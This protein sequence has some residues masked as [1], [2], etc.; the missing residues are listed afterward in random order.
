MLIRMNDNMKALGKKIEQALEGRSQSWLARQSGVG[1]S[2]VS[3]LIR[4][5]IR[6]SPDPETIKAIANALG[7]DSSHFMTLAG[8]PLPTPSSQLDP[9]ALHIAERI[10]SLPNQQRKEAVK[11]MGSVLDAISII[12]KGSSSF[13]TQSRPVSH[14]T[15]LNGYDP[16]I[17]ILEPIYEDDPVEE[18]ARKFTKIVREFQF[19]FPNEYSKIRQV[20]LDSP[21]VG[22]V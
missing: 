18:R 15:E 14:D 5:Q 22:L 11:A 9:A 21:V 10:S 12:S 17:K 1:Q 8:I 19:L 2:T 3:R 16:G 13:D 6:T 7:Q 4:G 20:L